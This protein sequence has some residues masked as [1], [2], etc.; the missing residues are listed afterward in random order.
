M[1]VLDSQQSVFIWIFSHLTVPAILQ[2]SVKHDTFQLT[3]H[4]L[5]VKGFSVWTPHGNYSL[6]TSLHFKWERKRGGGGAF[7]SASSP[8]QGVLKD[9]KQGTEDRAFLSFCV[10]R[11]TY[12]SF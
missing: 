5:S 6:A 12:F 4:F 3:G 11:E 9:K 2:L 8:V 10:S 7:V 1:L